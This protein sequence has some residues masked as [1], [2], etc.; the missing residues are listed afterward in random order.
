LSA[1][2][3]IFGGVFVDGD[4]R[5][6]LAFDPGAPPEAAGFA[7]PPPQP[8][9]EGAIKV[10]VP[11]FRQQT[12]FSCGAACLAAIARYFNVGPVGADPASVEKDF[13]RICKTTPEDGTTTE[14][15]E[16]AAEKLGLEVIFAGNDM[17]VAGLQDYLDRGFPVICNI[18]AWGHHPEGYAADEDD[19][20]YV[21]AVGYDAE[22]VYFED[23]SLSKTRGFI[24]RE[25]FEYR[26][27]DSEN[28]GV[29]ETHHWGMALGNS[30]T[31]Q[32][33]G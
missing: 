19:G 30:E 15:L 29:Q 6:D 25:M 9:R 33:I 32:P 27:H 8:V 11:S 1:L 5:A 2:P 16:Q 3:E 17:T 31:A 22:N 26:W 4:S 21:V 12:N 13:I 24:P 20:H 7:A 14:H 10:E 18:Q 23:P 28:G